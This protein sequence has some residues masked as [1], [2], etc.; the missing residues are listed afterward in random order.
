MKR[1]NTFILDYKHIEDTKAFCKSDHVG[2]WSTEELKSKLYDLGHG[3]TNLSWYIGFGNGVCY[4]GNNGGVEAC[5]KI[6]RHTDGC[7][8]FSVST[9]RDCYACFIYKTCN[10]PISSD[11]DYKIYQMEKSTYKSSHLRLNLL[12]LYHTEIYFEF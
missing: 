5:A 1:V 4:I 8:Y 11:H 9:T 2:E 6:C 3:P 7:Q 12:K 10:N